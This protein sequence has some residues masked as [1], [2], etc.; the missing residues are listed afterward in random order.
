MNES[1]TYARI[2]IKHW[3]HDSK[4]TSRKPAYFTT[5]NMIKYVSEQRQHHKSSNCH[6]SLKKVIRIFRTLVETRNIAHI[7]SPH[8]CTD[9]KSPTSRRRRLA[10]YRT[11]ANRY[12]RRHRYGYIRRRRT[13]RLRRHC[14][15][16]LKRSYCCWRRVDIRWRHLL[17]LL[18]SQCAGYADIKAQE[19]QWRRSGRRRWWRNDRCLLWRRS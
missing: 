17:L 10:V 6:E 3:W 8:S 19:R 15:L 16:I 7:Y 5:H 12:R 1:Y 11:S 13:S 18:W 2:C 4:S 9:V 14:R